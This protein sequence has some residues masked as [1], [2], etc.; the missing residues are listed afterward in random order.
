[1]YIALSAFGWLGLGRR[2]V[3]TDFIRILEISSSLEFQPFFPASQQS[4]GHCQNR[5]LF[6]TTSYVI[7]SSL[8]LMDSGID[9]QH[10]LDGFF[11]FVV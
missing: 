4:T 5:A 7:H 9:L 10:R 2:V 3:P 1:M 6:D 11:F 8:L